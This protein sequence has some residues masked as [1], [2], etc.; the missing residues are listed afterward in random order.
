MEVDI[1][2][3][4]WNKA[5]RTVEKIVVDAVCPGYPNLK[6]VMLNHECGQVFFI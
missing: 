1:Q 5:I 2:I 3:E 4:K 6:G